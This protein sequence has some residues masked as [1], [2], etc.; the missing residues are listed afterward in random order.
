LSTTDF[1]FL[2]SFVFCFV[3]YFHFTRR[4]FYVIRAFAEA[5]LLKDGLSFFR[6]QLRQI[7]NAVLLIPGEAAMLGG[8]YLL[9]G[10]SCHLHIKTRAIQIGS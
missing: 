6:N 2:S 1:I 9:S 8:A 10:L 7:A 4:T 5:N 3:F